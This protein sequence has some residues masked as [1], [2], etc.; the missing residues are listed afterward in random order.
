[1][2]TFKKEIILSL[3]FRVNREFTDAA[4]LDGRILFATTL[5]QTLFLL[6]GEDAL[7]V[8]REK[9][10]KKKR[11]QVLKNTEPRIGGH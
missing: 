3:S 2:I 10:K 11:W 9:E 8:F 1:M 6:K 5:Y 4:N 7:K